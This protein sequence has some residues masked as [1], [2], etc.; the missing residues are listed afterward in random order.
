MDVVGVV[1]DF[2]DGCICEI[3]VVVVVIGG[4]DGVDI[5]LE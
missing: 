1:G 4:D 2:G 3:N 5:G